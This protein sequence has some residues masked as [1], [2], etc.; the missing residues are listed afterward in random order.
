ME[1]VVSAANVIEFG[2]NAAAGPLVYDANIGK[3]TVPGVIDPT[4]M[5]YTESTLANILLGDNGWTGTNIG[6]LFV[7]DGT[8]GLDDNHLYYVF[9]D[10]T[11][12]KLS[13]GGTGDVVGPVVSTDHALVRWHEATGTII[14][15]SDAILTDTGDLTLSGD[16][17]V[18]KTAGGVNANIAV[19]RFVNTD[20]AKVSFRTNSASD[21]EIGTSA[22][23]SAFSVAASGA[24]IPISVT[25]AGAVT[26]NSAYTFPTADGGASGDVLTTDSIGNVSWAAPSGGALPIP[27]DEG[28]ILYATT[29]AAF[30]KATP[31]INSSGQ[32]V[33]NSDGHM[34]VV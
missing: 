12:L 19:D 11:P 2:P 31:M 23:S 27:D 10:G 3:L 21:W 33:M 32:I 22:G 28:Q 14:Q 29:S 1:V 13:G 20:A 17:A 34:V 25:A 30:V 6:G 15:N 18:V 5:I 4:G 16:L 26:I 24:S 9:E 7:S 8:V